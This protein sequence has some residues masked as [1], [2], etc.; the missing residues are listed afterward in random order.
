MT[1]KNSP[2]SDF[3]KRVTGRCER[4]EDKKKTKQRFASQR[5]ESALRVSEAASTSLLASERAAAALVEVKR[6]QH[7]GTTQKKPN[8]LA[9]SGATFPFRSLHCRVA[10]TNRSL[11]NNV[12]WSRRRREP[13]THD[14]TT[15]QH[16]QILF[17]LRC[18]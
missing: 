10:Q 16:Q 14:N 9:Q 17:L 15:T 2:D 7:E 1:L 11:V 5:S 12:T 3:W 13:E 4:R 8:N 6:I 18:V